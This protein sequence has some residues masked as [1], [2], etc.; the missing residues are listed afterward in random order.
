ML[1]SKKTKERFMNKK[2]AIS[3]VSIMTLIFVFV[4]YY[5]FMPAI[6]IKSELFWEIGRAS[7]R[8]RV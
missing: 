2:K 4:I 7:C 1:V 8:E 6:N 3:I 5:I